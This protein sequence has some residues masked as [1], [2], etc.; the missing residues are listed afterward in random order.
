MR[1]NERCPIG[2]LRKHVRA[3]FDAITH[4][5]LPEYLRELVEQLRQAEPVKSA[6]NDGKPPRGEHH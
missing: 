3:P 2:R 4:E 6:L 1:N 5:E